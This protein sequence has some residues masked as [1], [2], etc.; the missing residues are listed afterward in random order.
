MREEIVESIQQ[1]VQ[2]ITGKRVVIGS[3]P[4]L[5]GYAVSMAGGAP[6]A[7]FRP[8]T[9]NESF[10]VLFNGKGEDLHTVMADM[11]QAHHALT[12]SKAL[13]YSEDWQIYAIETTA[14]PSVIGREENRNWVLGSSLRVKFF[15]KKGAE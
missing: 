5:D 12:T 3:V 2:A 15:N 4:P 6:I 13:P 8:L 11:E 10:P 1:M 14:A 7:T 9:T